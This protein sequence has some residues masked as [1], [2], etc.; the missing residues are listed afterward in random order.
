MTDA[1]AEALSKKEE[2]E[3][4]QRLKYYSASQW[5]LIWW[6]FRRHKAAMVASFLLGLMALLGIFRRIR[7][8]YGPTTRDAEIYR[9]RAADPDVLRSERLFRQFPS[10]TGFRPNATRSPCAPFPCRTRKSASTSPS[11]RPGRRHPV[12]GLFPPTA[13]SSGCR[14]RTRNCISGARMTSG[15]MSFPA[16][17][18]PPAPRSPSACLGV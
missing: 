13:I 17:C 16:P 12:L 7:R 10:F 3:R 11:S 15:A 5:T 9:R 1:T 4:Q 6:R 14:T 2:K 18:M 8:P